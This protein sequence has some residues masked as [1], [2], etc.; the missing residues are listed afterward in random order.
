M[1]GRKKGPRWN[2]KRKQLLGARD[3]V[4]AARKELDAAIRA[5]ANVVAT[6]PGDP[7]GGK[8]PKPGTGGN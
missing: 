7:P 3:R 5:L 2:A 8:S 6:D 1:A 4:V